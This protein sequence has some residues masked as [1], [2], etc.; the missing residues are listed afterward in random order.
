VG[1]LP[2]DEERRKDSEYKTS[3]QAAFKTGFG[4]PPGSALGVDYEAAIHGS[5]HTHDG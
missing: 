4:R 5:E 1:S 3:A 2:D